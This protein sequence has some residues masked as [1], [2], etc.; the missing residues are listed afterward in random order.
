MIDMLRQQE[1]TPA[2]YPDT[3]SGLSDG[4]TA[5]DPSTVW[6]RIEAYTAHRFTDRQA[7]WTLEGA[8]NDNW[9]PPLTPVTSLSAEKWDGSAWVSATLSEGPFGYCIPSDGVFRITAQVGQGPVPAPVSEAFKRLAEYSVEIGADSMVTGHAAHQS[10]SYNLAGEVQE[11]FSRQATWAA[12]A[13]QNSGAG[14]LLRP[15]RRA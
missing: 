1:A 14:D 4:A 3:P 9:A 2:A 15:Y 7:I 10:H 13:I 8:E 11:D 12:R 5:L 6:A